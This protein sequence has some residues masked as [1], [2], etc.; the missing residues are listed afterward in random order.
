[1][2]PRGFLYLPDFVSHAEERVLL[3][4]FDHEPFAPM[5]VRGQITKRET[6][7]YGLAFKPYVASL[8]PAPP[9]PPYLHPLRNRTATAAGISSDALMQALIS[10]Y[11]E[12]SD[13]GWHIDH[14]SFGGF[15]ACV[16][17]LGSATLSFRRRRRHERVTVAPRS[18]YLLRDDARFEFEHKVVAHS[19]RFSITLRTI[20][21]DTNSLKPTQ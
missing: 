12:R 21:A 11:P 20:A 15:V 8:P 2:L 13:I 3:M 17:L 7:S 14:S 4:A 10:R 5:R 16:S 9:L 19:L 6:V 1:M 18:L